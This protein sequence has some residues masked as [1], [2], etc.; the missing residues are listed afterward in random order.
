MQ[1]IQLTQPEAQLILNCLYECPAKF[2]ISAI[3]L[4]NSKQLVDGITEKKSEIVKK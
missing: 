4:L 2:T 3:N 1:V